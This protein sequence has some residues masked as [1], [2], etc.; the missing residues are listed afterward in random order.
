MFTKLSLVS[1]FIVMALPQ[2][3]WGKAGCLAKD[4]ISGKETVTQELHPAGPTTLREWRSGQMEQ[5]YRIQ[6]ERIRSGHVLVGQARLIHDKSGIW[7]VESSNKMRLNLLGR[8]E[9]KT[10]TF[11]SFTEENQVWRVCVTRQEIPLTQQGV[12]TESEPSLDLVL[13]RR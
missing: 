9:K 10:K 13:F 12:A 1:F 3:S 4:A 11:K 8:N 7:Y 6:Y 5:P 2:A